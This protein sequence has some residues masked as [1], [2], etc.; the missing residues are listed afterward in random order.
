MTT[1]MPS[2]RVSTRKSGWLKAVKGGAVAGTTGKSDALQSM[3]LELGR[4]GFGGG[5]EYRSHVKGVGW[6]DSWANDGRT[7]GTSNKSRRIEAIQI[8]LYGEAGRRY[9]VYY[10]AHVQGLGWMAWAKNGAKAGTQG[11]SLR[12]EAIQVILVK[13]GSGTPAKNFCGAK[14]AYSK[15][16]VKK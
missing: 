13:K 15:A 5:I 3:R 9:D 2:V 14:Q 11:K 10:R 1:N 4:T 8:R 12:V 6:E 16:F 7:S